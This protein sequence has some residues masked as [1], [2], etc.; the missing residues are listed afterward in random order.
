MYMKGISPLP[1]LYV[2]N[3]FTFCFLILILFKV[4][5]REYKCF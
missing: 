2:S 4:L 5:I 3:I 1:A